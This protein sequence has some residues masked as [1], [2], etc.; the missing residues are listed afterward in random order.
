MLASPKLAIIV[1]KNQLIILASRKMRI[2]IYNS[3]GATVIK[4]ND[5]VISYFLITRNSF[6]AQRKV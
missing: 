3:N 5:K 1:F 4:S 6:R 2:K